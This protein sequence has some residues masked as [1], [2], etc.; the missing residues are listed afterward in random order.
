VFPTVDDAVIKKYL[1]GDYVKAVKFYD[2]RAYTSKRWFR[3]LSIY[4]IAVAAL[5]TPL[6]AF[7][8]D[9]VYWRIL[10]AALPTST[11]ISGCTH[12]ICHSKN[13]FE[14]KSH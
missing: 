11:V 6:V 5:L 10:A 14:R 12:D 3:S 1:D 9:E 13:H 4:V 7:A 2:D 8:P